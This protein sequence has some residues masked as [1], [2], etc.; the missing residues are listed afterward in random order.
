MR[1]KEASLE[2]ARS[3][4]DMAAELATTHIR[5]PLAWAHPHAGGGAVTATG[6]R[7]GNRRISETSF[8]KSVTL[9]RSGSLQK[10]F[11]K[12][13]PWRNRR[14]PAAGLQIARAPEHSA[15][16]NPYGFCYRWPAP[17]CDRRRALS[18]PSHAKHEP[19]DAHICAGRS[20]AL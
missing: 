12:I 18:Q 14:K 13:V 15:T 10:G 9:S 19:P 5:E 11:F 6:F 8:V 2:T 17:R 3:Y 4:R 16:R 1:E 7:P 20:D